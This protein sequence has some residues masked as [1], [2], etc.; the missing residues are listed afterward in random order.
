[1]PPIAAIYPTQAEIARALRIDQS[2]VSQWIRK[3]G[4]PNSSVDAAVAWAEQYKPGRHRR[5]TGPPSEELTFS[6]VEVPAAENLYELLSRLRKTEQSIAG[7]LAGAID[8]T[9]PAVLAERD[10]ARGPALT[11]AERKV[12]A[13]HHRI[14]GLRVEQR[15]VIASL[16]STEESIVKLEKHRGQL[17]DLD[18]ARDLI[19]AA[20]LPI[21]IVIRRLP[22]SAVNETERVRLRAISEM[23]LSELRANANEALPHTETPESSS[24]LQP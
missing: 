19:S 9:L 3:L 5:Q 18:A 1:M 23:L 17:I 14:A 4:M 13:C 8:I 2:T 11:V 24:P 16:V 12:A 21:V 6:V 22:D 7:Q 20:I 15:R 10:K